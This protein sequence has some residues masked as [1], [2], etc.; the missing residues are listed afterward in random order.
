MITSAL[1][2]TTA[3]VSDRNVRADK[4]TTSNPAF[5]SNHDRPAGV[6]LLGNRR[7]VVLD[8]VV[9]IADRNK[10]SNACLIANEDSVEGHEVA[11]CVNGAIVANANLAILSSGNEQ[12]AANKGAFPNHDVAVAGAK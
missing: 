3:P 1:A 11:S 10:F 4:D 6:S 7:S 9:L 5:V 8:A 2:A 12:L